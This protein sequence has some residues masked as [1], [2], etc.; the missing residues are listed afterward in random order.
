[1]PMMPYMLP[2]RSFSPTKGRNTPL[3]NRKRKLPLKQKVQNW[4]Q[5]N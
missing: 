3:V 1:M 5:E 4:N 2:T